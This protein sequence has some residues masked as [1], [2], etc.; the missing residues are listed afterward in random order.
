V[1][2]GAHDVQFYD[3][4]EFLHERVG[5]FL[6]DGLALGER[7]VVIASERN[8]RGVIARLAARGVDLA[9]AARSGRLVAVDAEE[10]LA[11]FADASGAPDRDR[12]RDVVGRLIG[13]GDRARRVRAFGEM[14]HVLWR[15]GD[16]DGALALE[17]LWDELVADLP[18]SLVCGYSIADFDG[19][20]RGE[21]LDRVCGRHQHVL[22][23]ETVRDDGDARQRE[24][25]RLQQRARG[26][27]HEIQR[28]EEVER[29]LR[30]AVAELRRSE[31]A[32][33]E[34]DRRKD[35]FLAMLGHELRNPLSAILTGVQLM[36]RGSSA[37]HER[38]QEIVERQARHLARLIDDLLDVSRITQGKVR[39][40]R[41]PTTVAEVISRAVEIVRP[42]VQRRAQTIRVDAPP[43]E[44]VVMAD[45]VRLAQV[46]GNL[47]ANA[48]KYSD[49]GS[50]IV[51]RARREDDDVV[52]SVHDHGIGIAPELL[53][54]IF[55]LFVQAEPGR[56]RSQGGL[57][58]GLTLARRLVEMHG[59]TIRA[60]SEGPGTGSE[61]VVRLPAVI[62]GV[63]RP[64]PKSARPP[65]PHRA[66]ERI[67]VV[68][69]NV[70]AGEVLAEALRAHGHEVAL[71]QDGVRALALA[72]AFRPRTA[73]L[74]IGLPGMDGYELAR[75]LRELD[76]ADGPLRLV[77][78]T[79]YGQQS[80]RA[81]S[82]AAGFDLHLV[83]PLDLERVVALFEEQA[84]PLR[85]DP[86]PTARTTATIPAAAS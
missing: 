53:P 13:Q 39:L 56:D 65:E 23:A 45:G 18:L 70:D 8:R 86:A 54:R 73:L 40:E 36:R 12:F 19:D 46:F 37:S 58:V 74:D 15:R 50:E 60:H 26:L 68:D 35:E 38:H 22:A 51:V 3:S 77:A 79:G 72:S 34:G 25:V 78:M 49:P 10:T 11:A 57:G 32:L 20:P 71:A 83:K 7:V 14:V 76:P 5:A 16:H 85:E 43:E 42:L 29:A 66:A 75:R 52:V 61:L 4:E 9:G 67:L 41:A 27:E 1:I 81:E 30:D 48:S 17:A 63:G 44:L 33:R 47:L 82:H 62:E 84:V 59:G 2:T 55:D 69:D 24:I 64:R 6:T 21:G 28:R 80:D 31:E